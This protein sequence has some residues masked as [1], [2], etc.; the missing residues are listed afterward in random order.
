MTRKTIKE[1]ED[2]IMKDIAIEA[3]TDHIKELNQRNFRLIK[4]C[5]DFKSW[6]TKLKIEQQAN[7][8]EVNK[9]HGYNEY[10]RTKAETTDYLLGEHI[11]KIEELLSINNV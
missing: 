2:N 7:E 3:M 1:M 6:L 10:T 4:T 9:S 11:E 5:N 8:T